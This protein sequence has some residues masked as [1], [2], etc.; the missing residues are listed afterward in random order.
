MIIGDFYIDRVAA[1]PDKT[2]SP[3]VVYANAVAPICCRKVFLTCLPV[4]PAG[5][6]ALIDHAQ[7]S[8]SDL[9]NIGRQFPRSFTNVYFL[10]LTVPEGLDHKIIL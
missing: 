7:F 9:L 5:R 1:F 4:E 2:N 8:Q 6:E 3:L 10:C